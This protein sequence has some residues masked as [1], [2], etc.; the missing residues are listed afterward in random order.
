MQ[1]E[2]TAETEAQTISVPAISIH[3]VVTFDTIGNPE[4]ALLR[5]DCGL[6]RW[7]CMYGIVDFGS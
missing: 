2:T 7:M 3:N 6:W 5:E 1:Q 4:V